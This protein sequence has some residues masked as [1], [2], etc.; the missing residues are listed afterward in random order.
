MGYC[1][2]K[3][4][5]F[6]VLYGK[7][8]LESFVTSLKSVSAVLINGNHVDYKTDKGTIAINCALKENDTLKILE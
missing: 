6:T 5:E 2:G 8:G 7:I 1:S 3:D 4:Y